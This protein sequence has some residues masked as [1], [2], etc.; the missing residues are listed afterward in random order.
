MRRPPNIVLVIVFFAVGALGGRALRSR[1]PS[2][3]DATQAKERPAVSSQANPGS[4]SDTQA[5]REPAVRLKQIASAANANKRGR[6]VAEIADD[7]DPAQIRE[8][9][10]ELD[11][12]HVRERSI[13][14]SLRSA[15]DGLT[16]S[17]TTKSG[18][19][20]VSALPR[21]GSNATRKQ[22]GPGSQ[23]LRSAKKRRTI[24]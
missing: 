13:K 17:P 15:L 21:G 10:A 8:A 11:K 14:L 22:P 7:L 12:T 2:S 6:L 1:A 18:K 23:T 4:S 24:C 5:P 19:R 9:L 16:P 3:T 20:A